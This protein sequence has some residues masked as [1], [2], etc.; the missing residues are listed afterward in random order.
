MKIIPETYAFFNFN[1]YIKRLIFIY[2]P[3]INKNLRKID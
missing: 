1:F 3:K 2:P